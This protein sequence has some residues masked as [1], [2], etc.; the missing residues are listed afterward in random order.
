MISSEDAA[1]EL[2]E[3]SV[4]ALEEL[5]ARSMRHHI[6]HCLQR[7]D[8]QQARA[9]KTAYF[10]GLSHSELAVRFA[11]PLGTLKSWI[12]RA[13]LVLKDCIDDGR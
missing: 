4:D 12:R 13:M 6:L 8:A 11:V 9:V 5:E 1:S 2:A 3:L 10:D 7:L